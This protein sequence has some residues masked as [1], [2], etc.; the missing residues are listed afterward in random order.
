[1]VISNDCK[2]IIISILIMINFL[3]FSNFNVFATDESNTKLY[4]VAIKGYDTVAYFTDGRA[5]KGKSVYSHNW[6]EARWYFSKPEN[7]DLFAA[8]P[9]RY[10]PE[11][12]GY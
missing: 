10:A 4:G 11:F 12:G 2:K 9:E 3:A 7:R 1:M 6:N 5:I 8:A